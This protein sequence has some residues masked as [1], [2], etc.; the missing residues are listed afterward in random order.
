MNGC[1]HREI[2]LI[3]AS[4][5]GDRQLGMLGHLADRQFNTIPR[6]TRIFEDTDAVA[7]IVLL[8][9]CETQPRA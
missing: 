9:R 2:S 6:K 4:L 3:S 7:A 5:R 1:K 8:S